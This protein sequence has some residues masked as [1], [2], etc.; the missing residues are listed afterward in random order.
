MRRP[1]VPWARLCLLLVVLLSSACNRLSFV[2]PNAERGDFRRTTPEVEIR[3]DAKNRSALLST[4]Q[5][6]QMR[7]VAG[8]AKAARDAAERAVKLDPR[9]PDAH[10]LLGLALDAQGEGVQAGP[11][12]RQAAE[13]APVR[14]S[15]LNNYGSWLCSHGQAA[16]SLAWFERAV[17][18]PGYETPAQALANGAMCALRAGQGERAERDARRVVAVDP[19]QPT[20]LMTLAHRMADTRR[21]LEARAFVERRLAAAPADAESLQLAS[22]IEQELGDT[23]A[24]ERYGLRL[25]T[26][27]PRRSG[28]AQEGGNP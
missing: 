9:S 15:L 26:E 11:H 23:A 8:D 19:A 7:L 24:A 21:W 22:Q 14:G 27:F 13:L 17:A 18:S 20:A 12:H 25:R 2:R 28:S 5:V 1:D 6:A 3:S 10:S 16:E 4:L